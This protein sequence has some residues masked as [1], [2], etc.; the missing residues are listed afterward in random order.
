MQNSHARYTHGSIGGTMLKTAAAMIPATVAISGYNIADTYFVARLGTLPLAAMGF[1]F[2]L[3]MLIGCLY[4]GLAVGAMTPLA[5][6]LGGRKTTKGAKVASSGLLLIVLCGIV[7]GVFGLLTMKWIFRQLGANEEVM[8]MVTSYMSIWYYGNLTVALGMTCNNLLI[9]SGSTKSA[10]AMMMGGMLLNVALDPLFI[11]GLGPFPAMGISGAALATVI[12]QALSG[13]AQL[14]ILHFRFHLL[15]ASVFHFRLLKSAWKIII[16]VAV[17]SIIGTLMMPIGNGIITRI[18]AGFGDDVVAAC[19]AGGRLEL[20]AFIVPMS[21]GI[22]LMPMIAQNYGGKHYDRIDQ[23]RIFAM[24][25]AV[26]FELFMAVAFFFAA[27]YLARLFSDDPNVLGPLVLYLRIIPFG[28]G[29]MEV[30]RYCGFIYTGCNRPA[31]AA[32]LNAL[33]LLGLLVPLSLLALYLRSLSGLFVARL[34]ADVLSGLIGL[35]LVRRLTM[36]LFH[37][38]IAR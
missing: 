28:F 26:I 33:R 11:F 5:H 24:R 3:I 38:H 20:A 30:H 9:A 21:L 8:P 13:G 37:G 35:W 23:C 6:S 7:I 36:K 22:A 29:M 27:P 10:S 18:A 19:A 31:A 16:R 32:W 15:T 14:V 34:A 4:R 2:P 17:P 12:A 1:T 25:F